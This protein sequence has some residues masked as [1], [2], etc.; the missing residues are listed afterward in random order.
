MTSTSWRVKFVRSE[1]VVRSMNIQA[2]PAQR[3]HIGVDHVFSYLPSPPSERSS[4]S[5]GVP[6]GSNSD[7]R[8]VAS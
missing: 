6:P 3:E 8:G 2:V 5:I 7:A 4:A 1:T